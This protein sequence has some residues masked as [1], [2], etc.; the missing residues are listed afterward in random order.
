M[1]SKSN[2]TLLYGPSMVSYL[3]GLRCVCGI[4]VG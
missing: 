3:V 1:V 4:S 2:A